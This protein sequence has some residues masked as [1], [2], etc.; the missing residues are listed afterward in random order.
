MRVVLFCTRLE[1]LNS[2]L[3]TGCRQNSHSVYFICNDH[4]TCAI[5]LV[6][7]YWIN[8]SVESS[9]RFVKSLSFQCERSRRLLAFIDTGSCSLCWD[10]GSVCLAVALN[11]D[12]V[13]VLFAT[14]AREGQSG[15]LSLALPDAA[16]PSKQNY[17]LSVDEPESTCSRCPVIKI[18][19]GPTQGM[20]QRTGLGND[21]K[22]VFTPPLSEIY[23]P[24]AFI[25]FLCS[26][27]ELLLQL[28]YQ[29]G[30]SA[31]MSYG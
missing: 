12:L 23:I 18:H 14:A 29:N 16:S 20:G 30:L 4:L 11:R 27:Y 22:N 10:N 31:R 26:E 7:A 25:E 15:A 9:E 17:V 13:P 1:L 19:F 21:T 8:A 28:R 2:F 24:K 6:F 5:R 3:M